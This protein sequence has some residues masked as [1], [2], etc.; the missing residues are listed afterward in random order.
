MFKSPANIVGL[1]SSLSFSVSPTTIYA[2]DS[3]GTTLTL[4][5]TG[6]NWSGTPFSI[7]GVSGA[8]ITSQTVNSARS[9]T[10]TL[11]TTSG[12]GTLAI[13]DGVRN[14]TNT[15]TVAADSFTISPTTI[16]ANHSGNITLTLSGLGT[17]WSS[18][19]FTLSG[20]AGVTKVSQT[21]NS[22]TSATVVLSTGSGTGT[23]SI[24]DGAI[25]NT[26]TVANTTFAL[27]PATGLYSVAPGTIT[28]TGSPGSLWT[29]ET[30]STLFSVP[31]TNGSSI[32]SIT[33]LSDT[34]A[35]FTFTPGTATGNIVVTQT[36]NGSTANFAILGPTSLHFSSTN[37]SSTGWLA[38]TASNN[39]L[40]N[41]TDCSYTLF[42][43]VNNYPYNFNDFV[44]NGVCA[45]AASVDHT[46]PSFNA[47]I[48]N[49]SSQQLTM[50]SYTFTPGVVYHIAMTW[51][52]ATNTQVYYVNGQIV[53]T[54]TSAVGTKNVNAP[55]NVG[56]AGN[57]ADFAVQDVA[58]WNGYALTSTE[59]KNLCHGSVT[60]KGTSTVA[61]S[62]WT[63]YGPQGGT[64]A[65][66]DVGFN[67]AIGSNNFTSNTGTALG[68]VTYDSPLVYTA[69]TQTVPYI[70]KSGQWAAFGFQR[71]YTSTTAI[72]GTV[73]VALTELALTTSVAQIAWVGSQ[74]RITGDSS[75][76]TYTIYAGSGQNYK[77]SPVYGGSA[78]AVNAVQPGNEPTH[79]LLEHRLV[80]DNSGQI[81]W[82]RHLQ[83]RTDR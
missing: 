13:S 76:T 44:Y 18:N 61:T 73:S 6:T 39:L 74:I 1:T 8:T 23:L 64:P 60:P 38:S 80:P 42:L 2:N 71:T 72:T 49:A 36:P 7:S 41:Q 54:S 40:S 77:I 25:S 83:Y 52:S 29:H 33:V 55:M 20:L 51:K 22:A 68:Q 78:N 50:P 34:S 45:L 12:T 66:G 81:R 67:D 28:A 46:K 58:V 35:T 62:W 21:I 10:I 47:F 70:T 57:V 69:P 9:A 26:T 17:S 56:F 53:G 30:A 4:T 37:P 82:C 79:E 43:K 5:G 32:S 15:V 19:I 24:S 63:F 31:G 16:P 48:F 75:N 59:V 14:A 3:I 27:S 65:I 11:T